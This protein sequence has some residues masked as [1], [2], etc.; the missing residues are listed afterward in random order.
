V[1]TLPWLCDP[2][3]RRVCLVW[4]EQLADVECIDPAEDGLETRY[5]TERHSTREA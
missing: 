2:A 5:V 3:S 1:P 4:P